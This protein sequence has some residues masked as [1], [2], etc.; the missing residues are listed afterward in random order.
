MFDGRLKSAPL[1]EHYNRSRNIR[2]SRSD[3]GPFE[4]RAERSS[5]PAF[6]AGVS[7]APYRRP[8]S[9]G[10]AA[11]VAPLRRAPADNRR[12]LGPRPSR[13]SEGDPSGCPKIN[14]G[15]NFN[16][17]DAML[18]ILRDTAGVAGSPPKLAAVSASRP[19]RTWTGGRRAYR[20]LWTAVPPPY[21]RPR[22]GCRIAGKCACYRVSW[23]SAGL[24][25]VKPAAAGERAA[26]GSARPSCRTGRCRRAP[27][28]SPPR[29]RAD[30]PPSHRL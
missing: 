2:R 9:T 3:D 18:T 20:P 14:P 8:E 26:A 6:P 24:F 25:A 13:H 16:R 30:C 22:I 11:L 5:L 19:A 27:R 4:S 1:I 29:S 10:S 23:P 28:R 7:G 21:V 15:E 12:R 17:R